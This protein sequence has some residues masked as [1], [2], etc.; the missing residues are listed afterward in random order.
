MGIEIPVYSILLVKRY[1]EYARNAYNGESKFTGGKMLLSSTE[2][3]PYKPTFYV[4]QYKNDVYVSIKGSKDQSDFI[5]DFDYKEEEQKFGKY[6][7]KVHGG[8]CLSAQYIYPKIQKILKNF[9]KGNIY[10]TGHS[11]GASIATILGLYALTDNNWKNKNIGVIAIAPAP[12]VSGIPETYIGKFVNFINEN[13]IVPTLS[14]SNG[15]HM[16]EPIVPKTNF[17]KP[18][19]KLALQ[20][21]VKALDTFKSSFT[22]L[23][24]ETLSNTLDDI[25]DDIYQYKIDRSSI[26]VK[27]LKGKTYKITS[28]GSSSLASYSFNPEQAKTLSI[29]PNSIKSHSIANYIENIEHI[30]SL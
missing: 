17:A 28:D 11:M 26:A 1:F 29:G 6:K 24:I 21:A 4:Y 10:F 18:L 22:D 20:A 9:T 25:V 14:I 2:H 5:V 19:V 27:S 23:F 16:I 13:D 15:F 7:I 30:T 3:G 12:C 8:F